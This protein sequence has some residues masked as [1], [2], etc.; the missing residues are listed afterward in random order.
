MNEIGGMNE[1]ELYY[2]RL[3]NETLN[4]ERSPNLEK[5]KEHAMVLAI[6]IDKFMD[7]P[8]ISKKVKK[9]L[10]IARNLVFRKGGIFL[11]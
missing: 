7:G 11:I 5:I 8:R 1:I 2:K 3:Y 6:S 9:H 10:K 4:R